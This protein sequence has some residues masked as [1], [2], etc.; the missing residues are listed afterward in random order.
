MPN[1]VS[2]TSKTSKDHVSSE[3]TIN[4]NKPN[5]TCCRYKISARTVHSACTDRHAI[6]DKLYLSVDYSLAISS[7]IGTEEKDRQKLS[8]QITI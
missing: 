8:L 2:T 4:L 5:C 6:I 7:F 3:N 1:V